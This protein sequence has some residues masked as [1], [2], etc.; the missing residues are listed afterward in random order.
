MEAGGEAL[1]GCF[2]TEMVLVYLKKEKKKRDGDG[3]V[4][5][6]KHVGCMES[7]EAKVVAILEVLQ[8]FI[9]LTFKLSWLWKVTL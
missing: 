5:F 2:V 7:N 3:L 9:P 8:I 6:F 1:E 4:L